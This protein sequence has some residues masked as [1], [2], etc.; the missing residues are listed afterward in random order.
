MNVVFK[1]ILTNVWIV[2]FLFHQIF[3]Q[4]LVH[5]L[6]Q[7]IHMVAAKRV[8][9][10]EANAVIIVDA[11]GGS[12]SPWHSAMPCQ[13]E[14]QAYY[15]ITTFPKTFY[16]RYC[17]PDTAAAPTAPPATTTATSR[18]RK[19]ARLCYCTIFATDWLSLTSEQV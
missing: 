4:K 13:R 19:S 15:F 11:Q 17:N 9:Q 14:I 7:V 3:R 18:P 10:I 6:E 2:S 16:K 8:I 1:R 12:G 5:Q